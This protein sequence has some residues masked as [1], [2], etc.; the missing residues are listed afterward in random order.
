MA[1]S[2]WILGRR[3]KSGQMLGAGFVMA[4]IGMVFL[5]GSPSHVKEN[6]GEVM[7]EDSSISLT[8]AAA[9]CVCGA[10]L[11]AACAV[12]TEAAL[13]QTLKEEEQRMITCGENAAAPSKLLLSNA[14]SMWTTLFAFALLSLPAIL[15]GQ[16]QG[17]FQSSSNELG[18]ACKL[19]D[20]D[21]SSRLTCMLLLLGVMR[22]GE[23]LS[24]HWICV[25][26]SAVT[27]SL[28]QAARRLSGVFILAAVC[29]E[30]FPQ[31]MI[32][33]SLSSAIG[34]AMHVWY[35]RPA[36]ADEEEASSTHKSARHEYEL[37]TTVP[38]PRELPVDDPD[39]MHQQ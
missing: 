10:C 8:V 1:L 21:S 14:Y 35:G 33:G 19:G 29:R 27:F 9:F 36:A 3:Y 30:A 32:A 18:E 13:K 26:D 23:R 34:L 39:T 20:D 38:I 17:A 31:S 12:L 6:R 11:N 7:T 15:S 37:V 24:K 22:F 16:L 5:L 2:R 28:V 25:S 4:G